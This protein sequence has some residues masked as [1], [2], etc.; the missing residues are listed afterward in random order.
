MQAQ[1]CLSGFEHGLDPAY[2][3]AGTEMWAQEYLS[4]ILTRSG[5]SLVQCSA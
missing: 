5:P 3:S 4:G 2:F 1:E